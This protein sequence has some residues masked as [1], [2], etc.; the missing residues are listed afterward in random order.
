MFND[1]F[2]DVIIFYNLDQFFSSLVDWI[3][4]NLFYYLIEHIF[5]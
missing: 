4:L 3:F 5:H 1:D 2:V